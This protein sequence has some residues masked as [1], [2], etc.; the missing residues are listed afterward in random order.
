MSGCACFSRKIRDTAGR[1]DVGA[2]RIRGTGRVEKISLNLPSDVRVENAPDG[3]TISGMLAAGDLDAVDRP[4]APSCFDRG[5]PQIGYLFP[6]PQRAAADWYRRTH[7]FP[8][9]HTLGIRRTLAEQHPWLPSSIVKAF[10]K[11]KAIALAKLGD[12]SATKV[13]LPFVEEQLRAARTLMGED[14]WAYGLAPNR[15]V[16]ERFLQRHHSEGLSPAASPRAR[17][18]FPPRIAEMYKI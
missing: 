2:R 16:L 15:R 8:I 9:M 10:E 4:R 6:D 13:T 11:S 14:F 5:D 18:A 7:L 1:R 17:G 3:A 12:T